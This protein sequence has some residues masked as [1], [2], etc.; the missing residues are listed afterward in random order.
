MHLFLRLLLPV[1]QQMPDI[2]CLIGI[3]VLLCLFQ[4]DVQFQTHQDHIHLDQ[5]F[6]RIIP[7]PGGR[8]GPGRHQR[9][10]LLVIPQ[11]L[12]I[13]I[14]KLGKFADGE[15]LLHLDSFRLSP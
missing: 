3:P 8:I 11:Q 7:V 15:I 13:D 9:P 1:Q 10:D 6:Q 2:Q 14:V 12:L 5:L 4:R